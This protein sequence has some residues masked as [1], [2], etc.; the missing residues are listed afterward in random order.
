MVDREV[1][2]GS[3]G[4]GL[5]EHVL[6]EFFMTIEEAFCR[7]RGAPLLLSSLDFEKAIEWCAAGITPD[8]VDEGIRRYFERLK[9]RKVPKRRAI[10]LSFAENDILKVREER[11]A[12]AVG[13]AA[14]IVE[15]AEEAGKRVRSFLEARIRSVESFLGDSSRS[16]G[17]PV[18]T[19]RLKSV[20]EALRDLAERTGESQASLEEV[21]EPLDGEVGRLAILESP[22]EEVESWRQEARVRL[23]DVA[24]AME[25]KALESTLDRLCRQ[26]AFRELGLPR[27]SLLFLE[28]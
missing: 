25:G 2:A 14:G 3:G 10:C 19:R 7:H 6:G 12:A 17:R 22:E 26:R 16:A 21:L 4:E 5:S 11:R 23:G 18:L 15:S 24:G 8:V 1:S 28:G 13:R 20:V 27:L 9:G